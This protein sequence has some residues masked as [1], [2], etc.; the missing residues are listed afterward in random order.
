MNQSYES[1]ELRL[2]VLPVHFTAAWQ[3]LWISVWHVKFPVSLV[4]SSFAKR[5]ILVQYMHCAHTIV[6]IRSAQ[7]PLLVMNGASSMNS[8]LQV[9]P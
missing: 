2:V 4:S 7:K 8:D 3:I 6:Y 5:L 1:D 9:F